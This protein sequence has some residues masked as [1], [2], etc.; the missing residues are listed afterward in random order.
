V[1]PAVTDEQGDTEADWLLL[2]DADPDTGA[3]C[4]RQPLADV[5]TVSVGSI[6]VPLGTPVRD[7]GK[8]MLPVPVEEGHAVTFPE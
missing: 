4:V 8:E 3:L 6:G 7:G 2:S 5:L 1:L